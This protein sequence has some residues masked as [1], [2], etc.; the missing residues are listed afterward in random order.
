[1]KSARNTRSTPVLVLA[2][3]AYA[4][5][6][7]A[8]VWLVQTPRA[9]TDLAFGFGPAAAE[10]ARGHFAPSAHR[11]P[12]VPCYLGFMAAH[13]GHTLI[14]LLAKNALTQPFLI[15][16]LFRILPR[17]GGR[18]ATAFALTCPQFVAHAYA[19]IPEEGWLIPWLAFAAYHLVCDRS[20]LQPRRLLLLGLVLA[21]ILLTKSSM[22]ILCPAL[23]IL[24]I[25]RT[26]S[27]VALMALG[28]CCVAAF[29][30]WGTYNYA[31]TGQFRLASS[32]DGYN[33]Y[34]G[35][36]PRAAEV[37][38]R[39]SLDELSPEI[40][41]A[42]DWS[43]EWGASDGY[44]RL[45]LDFWRADRAA[46]CRLFLMRAYRMFLAVTPL[47]LGEGGPAIRG[48]HLIGVAYMLLFRVLFLGCV[49]WAAWCL[50]RRGA[51]R[52]VFESLAFLA[53]TI[54][55]SAPYLLAFAYERHAL[56]LVV[57]T[58]LFAVCVPRQVR[59]GSD[60]SAGP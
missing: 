2:F 39:R 37:Y 46:A 4:F 28:A 27:R 53:F 20:E 12:L 15:W 18:W 32:L 54:F 48:L 7:C 13:G 8:A 38:A 23:A 55:Y 5:A 49:G 14:A 47:D 24:L 43:D 59:T 17:R 52:P 6:A 41:A 11:S 58:L 40:V 19:L 21:P 35:N 33:L 57:P 3:V 1:M 51:G 29:L 60:A 16:T 34:K 44:A 50:A 42:A 30:A 9:I 26:R 25:V 22:R 31:A 45:A 36:N 56:G 10:I